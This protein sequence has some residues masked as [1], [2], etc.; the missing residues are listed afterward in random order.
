MLAGEMLSGY[1]TL[2]DY[3]Y[4]GQLPALLFAVE[5]WQKARDRFGGAPNAKE[6]L[7]SALAQIAPVRNETA[8]VREVAPDRLQRASLAC[9][10]VLEMLGSVR[11]P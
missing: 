1:T 8:H 7:Q 2:V 4:L 10:D 3:L 9:G 6:K 5:A 11:R